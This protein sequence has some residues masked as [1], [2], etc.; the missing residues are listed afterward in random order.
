MSKNI[1]KKIL[2]L[3]YSSSA[4]TYRVTVHYSDGSVRRTTLD[5]VIMEVHLNRKLTHDDV[6]MFKDGNSKNVAYKNLELMTRKEHHQ[7]IGNIAYQKH[8]GKS[9]TNPNL[10]LDYFKNIDT[11]EKAY[12][13][14]FLAADGCVKENGYVIQFGLK[15]DDIE[16]VKKFA[17]TIG[18]NSQKIKIYNCRA[19]KTDPKIHRAV[20]INFH[21]KVFY[22]NLFQ[23]GIVPRKSKI[24]RLPV[25]IKNN[26]NLLY[27][28]ILGYYD[29]D[30]YI[31][32]KTTGSICSGSKEFLQDVKNA[33]HIEKYDIKKKKK[34]YILHFD[35]SIMKLL[36]ES[37]ED[38]LP[39][40]RLLNNIYEMKNK[41]L[42][43]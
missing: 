40:K 7:K 16:T 20:Y 1:V 29:G 18:M 15:Y 43:N 23:H 10:K 39:R 5:R 6:V 26:N 13:L 28:F 30:G 8:G 25:C 12:W 37:Y 2:K 19:S 11:T 9:K 3:S 31:T 17:I 14:G 38:S 33:L 36:F 27:A 42:N 21:N 34:C 32:G 35:K 24:L 4:R 41:N 22:N